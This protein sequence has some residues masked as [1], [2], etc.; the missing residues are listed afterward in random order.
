LGHLRRAAD[1]LRAAGFSA[2]TDHGVTD[3]GD[4]WFVFCDAA[5]GDVFAHF[6]RIEGRYVAC[7]PFRHDALSGS[8]LSALID[9][10]FHFR[11]REQQDGRS[12]GARS[13]LAP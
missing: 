12:S 8:V 10:F 9:D 13:T 11:D 1:L 2:D 5:T 7:V 3:Q 4:P 6:A